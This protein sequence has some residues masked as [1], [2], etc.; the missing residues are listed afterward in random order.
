MGPIAQEILLLFE[1]SRRCEIIDFE[2]H[3][4]SS[5]RAEVSQSHLND[6]ELLLRRGFDPLHAVYLSAHGVVS[7]LCEALSTLPPLEPFVR[8]VQTAEGAYQPDGPPFSA[9]T[10]S[11]F[12][13]WVFFDAPCGETRETLGCCILALGHDL[14]IEPDLL[15]VIRALRD[16]RMGIYEQCGMEG[17]WVL[18]RDVVD[19]C[20][21]PCHVPTGYQGEKGALW[22][23]RLLPSLAGYAHTVAFTTPYILADSR[24]AWLAFFNRTVPKM[25]APW[26]PRA[27]SEAMHELLK[28]GLDHEYWLRYIRSAYVDSKDHV[29]FLSGV[30]DAREFPDPSRLF[31]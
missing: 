17:A 8:V 30:P 5:K 14:A 23:V 1:A 31:F 10:R 7:W 22:Y 15:T 13:N 18:L 27:V 25:E 19:G 6:M 26:R 29:I 24:E 12:T 9:V 16:S 3:V 20:C 4:T 11:Y 28:Y 21:Y 2:D